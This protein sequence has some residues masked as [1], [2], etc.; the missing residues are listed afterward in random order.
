MSSLYTAFSCFLSSFFLRM[1]R[2]RRPV[3]RNRVHVPAP[4]RRA[5]R[6]LVRVQPRVEDLPRPGLYRTEQLHRIRRRQ[7]A[8]DA[9]T[10]PYP[11]VSDERRCRRDRL[12]QLHFGPMRLP[13]GEDGARE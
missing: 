10:G 11:W 8:P 13:R 1:D 3:R 4:W 7:R 2:M 6:R 9:R 12:G 5:R